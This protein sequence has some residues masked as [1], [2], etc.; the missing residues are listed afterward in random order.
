MNIL[1]IEDELSIR[2]TLQDLLELNG[3][4]VSVAEDGIAGVKLAEHQPDLILC[5]VGMPEMDGYAVI[6]SIRG[7][8]SCRDIPFIFL[9]ARAS[10]DDQ[11]RGM[12]LG[13][14]DY[15]T[16][17]FTE[18]EIID[19]IEARVRRQKPLR[20]RVEKLLTERLFVAG[21]RWSHELMT[22]L[23]GILGGLEL[24]EAEAD[25]IQADELRVL[26]GLIRGS[27]E[28]QHALS[29][30]LMF[31]YELER[32]KVAASPKKMFRCDA[33]ITIASG[34]NGAA[35]REGRSSDLAVACE[36]GEIAILDGVLI[37]AVAEVVE[38]ACR[39]S[40]PGQPVTVTGAHHGDR[41]RI[42]II[43]Q[44]CGMTLEECAG[45]GPFIQFERNKFEQRG[46]GLGVSLAR[47]V[48]EL[49]GGSLE[50]Q[51]GPGNCG[52]HAS[53]DLPCA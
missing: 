22:P 39:F 7:L 21:A 4:T 37:S 27:A 32:R 19:A 23:N 3:H 43:D 34:A 14:D 29:R 52:V 47:A 26:L 31:H 50:L 51:P 44:G 36:A 35:K 41:Y 16:K 10:R 15:I 42:E 12:A 1:I 38:N 53:F 40:K 11:R 25:T 17:P 13:A 8:P 46:L 20:E 30:K 5:D 2:Q 49:A 45:I 48:A 24:I 18:D 33:P 9:T 28:R 6:E